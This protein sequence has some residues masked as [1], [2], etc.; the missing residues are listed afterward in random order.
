M[1]R[2]L[3]VLPVPQ[4]RSFVLAQVLPVCG[5]QRFNISFP[6][7][8]YGFGLD[9]MSVRNF[10]VYPV[11]HTIVHKALRDLAIVVEH[12]EESDYLDGG[13]IQRVLVV[14]CQG[15]EV[16]IVGKAAGLGKRRCFI[17]LDGNAYLKT[18]CPILRGSED[19]MLRC[20]VNTMR[21]PGR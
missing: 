9:A 11:F 14:A 6:N 4:F 18:M 16:I 1:S 8:D 5:S 13:K 3:V 17:N 21:L 12:W 15:C 2:R 20:A 7:F 10:G 19:S